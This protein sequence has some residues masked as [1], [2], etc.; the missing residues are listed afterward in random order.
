[1]HNNKIKYEWPAFLFA[2]Q[3]I[4]IWGGKIKRRKLYLLKTAISYRLILKEY[5][6]VAE[7]IKITNILIP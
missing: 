2:K 3:N 7:I 5:T 1:V 6:D 4:A